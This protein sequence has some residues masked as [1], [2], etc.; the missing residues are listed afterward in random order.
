MVEVV[1]RF[2]GMP[3]RGRLLAAVWRGVTCCDQGTGGLLDMDEDGFVLVEGVE[4]YPVKG[5]IPR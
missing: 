4:I 1:D 2:P 3:A 5:D